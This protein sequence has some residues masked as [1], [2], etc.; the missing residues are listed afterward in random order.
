M[1]WNRYLMVM[2]LAAALLLGGVVGV[3]A[4]DSIAGAFEVNNTLPEGAELTVVLYAEGGDEPLAQQKVSATDGDIAWEFSGLGAG[5]HYVDLVA[6][7]GEVELVLSRQESGGVADAV[8]VDG[9]VSGAVTMVGEPPVW[10]AA[11]G[12]GR[13][14]RY[15]SLGDARPTQSIEL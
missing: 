7:V 10:L 8:G 6:S 3:L 1:R 12:A 2:T 11:D 4:D 15:R 5:A 14:H 9:A 13:S